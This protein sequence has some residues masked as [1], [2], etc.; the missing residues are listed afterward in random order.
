[1][2]KLFDLRPDKSLLDPTFESYKLSLETLPIY[3]HELPVG[4][5]H[6]KPSDDQFSFQ[7]YKSFGFHNHLIPDVWHPDY[8]YFISK[9]YKIFR[10]NLHSLVSALITLS[11]FF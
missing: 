9:D 11:S 1:M 10:T 4:V 8:V 7:H 2:A 5:E 3:Q 6:L